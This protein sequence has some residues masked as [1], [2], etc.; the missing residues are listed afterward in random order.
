MRLLFGTG[1]P[2]KLAFM[3]HTLRDFDFEIIGLG[4]LEQEIPDIAEDGETPL[5]NAKKKALGYY[6]A[7]GMPVF[8]CDSGLYIDGIPQQEQ[9]GVH[10]RTIN[11]KYLSDDEMI[12]YYSALAIKYGNLNAKYRNAICLV[13]DEEHVYCAMEESMASDPFLITSKPHAVRR[14]GFPLDSLSVDIKTGKYFYDLEGT[15]EDQEKEGFLDFFRKVRK[16][17][18]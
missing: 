14:E 17:F 6:H 13:L 1:N 4:D 2:A 5:E 11:G 7:F 12:E 9:P 3:R 15:K 8:S 10:V 16:D 18:P